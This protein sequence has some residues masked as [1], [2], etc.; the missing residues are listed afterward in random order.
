MKCTSYTSHAGEH[1]CQKKMLVFYFQEFVIA[2]E[3]IRKCELEAIILRL[4]REDLHPKQRGFTNM[5][6]VTGGEGPISE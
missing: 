4:H 6:I 2:D 5:I 1:E 3:L